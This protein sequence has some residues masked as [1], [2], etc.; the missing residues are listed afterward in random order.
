MCPDRWGWCNCLPARTVWV[1]AALEAGTHPCHLK[2]SVHLTNCNSS[3]FISFSSYMPQWWMKSPG[4]VCTED[5]F[6]DGFWQTF[7]H[8]MPVFSEEGM[9]GGCRAASFTP[10]PGSS[11]CLSCLIMKSSTYGWTAYK[12]GEKTSA[13]LWTVANSLISR[14]WWTGVEYLGVGSGSNAILCLTHLSDGT[15]YRGHQTEW[16]GEEGSKTIWNMGGNS[17]QLDLNW[18]EWWADSK[19]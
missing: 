7:L 17:I 2:V 10:I 8:I 14:R 18:L 11:G 3:A 15:E 4:N 1:W 6:P 12:V 16:R 5:H 13:L 19:N 9:W